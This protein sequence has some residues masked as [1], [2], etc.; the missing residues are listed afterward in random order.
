MAR[1]QIESA[2]K[3]LGLTVETQFVPFSQSRNKAE[4]HPSLNWSVTLWRDTPGAKDRKRQPILTTDYMA[5][6]G[7]CPSSKASI[8]RLGSPNC[9]MRDS[10]IR[11]ECET[12]KEAVMME[13]INHIASR[14]QP[15]QPD[16]CDVLY[17]LASDSDAIDCSTFEEWAN[18]LGYEPDSRKAESIYR[19]C[20]EIALKLRAA[21]G[22]AGLAELRE[23]CQDF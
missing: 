21:I 2:A 5:G 7:H 9:I 4:K 10:A 12:G 23:A 1:E 19:A 13:G 8:K 18:N 14:G 15:L 11:H 20:L 3:K 6:S 22:D 17:S 16:L